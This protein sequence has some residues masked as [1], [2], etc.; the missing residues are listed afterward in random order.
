MDFIDLAVAVA[1]WL[2]VVAMARGC[3]ALQARAGGRP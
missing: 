3:A 2:T 1:L